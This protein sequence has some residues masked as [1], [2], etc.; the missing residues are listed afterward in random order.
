MAFDLTQYE[1]VAERLD[2]WLKKSEQ[3]NPRVLTYM[4]SIPGAD[5][6]VIKAELWLGDTRIATGYAEE[7]RG[8]NRINQ[9]NHVEVCETSA[10]GRAL[11][12]A[13]YAGSDASKRPSR[14]EMAKV[15][16]GAPAP[17]TNKVTDIFPDAQEITGGDLTVKG[18]QHGE[19]P[20]WL[21]AEAQT[22]G[23]T[24]VWDNRDKVAG[25]KRPWFKDVNGDKAFWPPKGTPDPVIVAPIVEWETEE[26]PF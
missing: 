9:I 14:E 12:N 13:G 18:N 22:F 5:V 8:S 23:V 17:R 10:I 19:L 21:Y 6:C 3:F 25:T 7:I 4:E 16:R 26:E 1:P 15:N 20:N 2:R 11:A 24:Q